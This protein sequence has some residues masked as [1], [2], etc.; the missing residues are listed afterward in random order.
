M[1]KFNEIFNFSAA[2][3]IFDGRKEFNK[4]YDGVVQHQDFKVGK[5]GGR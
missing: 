4:S 3:T 1:K 5:G 2:K